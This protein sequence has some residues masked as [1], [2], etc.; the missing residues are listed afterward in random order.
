MSANR[1]CTTALS[2]TTVRTWRRAATSP[3][4]AKVIS[5]SAWGRRR[6]ALASVVRMRPSENRARARLAMSSFSWAGPPPR[7][8]PLVGVGIWLFLP[9]GKAELLELL[10]HLVD[11]LGAE[12][13]DV[14]QVGLGLGDQLADRGDALALQAVVGADRQVELLDRRVQ[15]G[16]QRAGLLGRAE[17]QALAAA[18]QVGEQADQLAQ[19]AAG[20]GERVLRGQRAVGL[21]VQDQPVVVGHLA[22]AGGLDGVADPAHGREDRVDRDAADLVGGRLVAL[23]RP[24]AAALLDPQLHLQLGLG[25]QGGQVQLGVDDVDVGRGDDVGRGHVTGAGRAQAQLLDVEDDVGDVLLHALDGRELVQD[26]VDLDGRDRGARDGRQQGAA[27]RVAKGVAEA[28]LQRLDDE[29]RAGVRQRVGLDAWTRDLHLYGVHLRLPGPPYDSG[30]PSWLLLGVEL[31]DELLLDGHLDLVPGRDGRDGQLGLAGVQLEPARLGPAGLELDRL[32]HVQVLARALLHLDDVARLDLVGGDVD[33][34][35]VDGHVRVA[36]QLTRLVAAPGQAAPVDH[37]VEAR[38]QQLEQRLAGDALPAGRLDVVVVELLLEHAVDAAGLLLLPELQVVLALL[39]PAAAVLAGRVGAL[40]HRA[41]GALALGALEEELGLLAPAE[42][43]VR[44]GVS[45]QFLLALSDAAPLGRAAA[46]VGD[47]GDVLDALDLQAGGLQGADGRL[48]ARPRALDEHV[49]LADAVLLGP[50]GGLLGR[51]L[52]RERGRLARALE[53]DVARRRPR[54]R[55]ALGVGDGH[56][57]V[58]EAG[59]DVGMG[60]RDV[61]LLAPPGLLGSALL[62]WQVFRPS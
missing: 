25:V 24:V 50:A 17:R 55:V 10:A 16:P 57:R 44:A 62:R 14:E 34:P 51:Q 43:A 33:L 54:D 45:R 8:G 5:R 58:V 56:D 49:D 60:V 13:A 28:G 18:G 37:V 20:R 23:G 48:P 41:L 11:R 52:G 15:V 29:P 47:G 61:L 46:V 1:V 32:V 21:D 7:R 27:Q 31:D 12:V 53:P 36:H 26:A 4:L 22:R 2:R 38:L 35:A 30:K 59:L 40:L 6:L 3:R 19:G 9:Q 42:P 39:E